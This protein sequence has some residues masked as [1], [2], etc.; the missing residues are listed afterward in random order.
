MTTFSDLFLNSSER[1]DFKSNS[2]SIVYF[3]GALK[4]LSGNN[5][6][7]KELSNKNLVKLLGNI[8]KNLSQFVSGT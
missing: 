5:K 6:L 2:D 1:L 7:L 4:N 3:C 8:S